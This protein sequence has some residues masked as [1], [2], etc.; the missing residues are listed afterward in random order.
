VKEQLELLK[1]MKRS[2]R[3]EPGEKL[4]DGTVGS[5]Y[6]AR[7]P[8][9]GQVV[10]LK[11]LLPNVC[12]QEQ[13]RARFLREMY[14]L[15]KLSHR[16]I[17]RYYGGGQTGSQLF[18]AM[19]LL[20]GGS[21]KDLILAHGKLPWRESVR[22]AIRILSAL[23]HAHNHGIIHRDIKPSNLFLTREG[24][25]VLGDFGIAFD[26]EGADITHD[27]MAVGTLAYSSP[28]QIRGDR[29]IGG[30]AD[31]Y[32]LGCVL[33]EMLTGRLPFRGTSFAQLM[34]GHLHDP[35][36][37]V[38]DHG[39]GCPGWLDEIIW[40]MMQKDPG[41]RPFNARAVE[42]YLMDHLA[43]QEGEASVWSKDDHLR[44]LVAADANP[45]DLSTV[46]ASRWLALAG[47][48]ILLAGAAWLAATL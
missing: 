17:V 16:N 38:N 9:T 22:W 6:R 31:L 34:H 4:G 28:E 48:L 29:G 21:I 13:V 40:Q 44:D 47:L 46:P 42:G 33:F 1:S 35:P 25:I 36:P 12:K 3:Y 5:V 39:A 18:Y 37:H 19:E 23:Q 24:R 10:A 45:F 43:E 32:S 27:G 30:Q 11:V 15:E 26:V 41:A 14:V 7:N 8:D 20:D 2:P